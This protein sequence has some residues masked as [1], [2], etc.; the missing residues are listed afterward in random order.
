MFAHPAVPRFPAVFLSLMAAALFGSAPP[1]AQSPRSLQALVANLRTTK[2]GGTSGFASDVSELD[3]DNG[4]ALIKLMDDPT[5]RV[6][7]G[8]INAL[9]EM[10]DK[11]ALDAIIARLDDPSDDVRSMAAWSLGAIR[12]PKA[13]PALIPFVNHSTDGMG[14]R[15][16][17]ALGWIG[18]RRASD[19]L[20]QVVRSNRSLANDACRALGRLKDERAVPLL[21]SVLGVDKNHCFASEGIGA[22]ALGDNAVEGLAGIGPPA[23]D[24]LVRALSDKDVWVRERAASALAQIKDPRSA[25]ALLML[26]T[27]PAAAPR[28]RAAEAL[29]ALKEKRAVPALLAWLAAGPKS[30]YFDI[31][32]SSLGKIGDSRAFEPLKALAESGITPYRAD[33]VEAMGGIRDLRTF[34]YLSAIAADR[35]NRHYHAAIAALGVQQD[36]RAL[37]ILEAALRRAPSDPWPILHA[38]TAYRD[39]RAVPFLI[40]LG[41]RASSEGYPYFSTAAE[42]GPPGVDAL[43]GLL[44]SAKGETIKEVLMALSST[45]ELRAIPAMKELLKSDDVEIQRSARYAAASIGRNWRL[46][47]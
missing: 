26:L 15:A 43:I 18:D 37:P 22:M 36:P 30:T 46:R 11:R 1:L 39:V 41:C 7:E 19:P 21:V 9:G 17:K 25:G 14:Y 47:D 34:N 16:I 29:G 27:D 40:E 28:Y 23:V 31:A 12:D 35:G 42:L 32:V 2:Y 38:I 44:K 45:R 13:V 4:P 20:M 24:A 3:G 5:P 6:R 8:A 10:G 33:I